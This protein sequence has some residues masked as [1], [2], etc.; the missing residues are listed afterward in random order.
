MPSA[1]EVAKAELLRL[2]EETGIAEEV[3][4]AYYRGGLEESILALL[5]RKRDVHRIVKHVRKVYIES[6]GSIKKEYVIKGHTFEEI[7]KEISDD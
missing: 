2:L 5:K 7:L 6:G 4:Q 1:E 3:I